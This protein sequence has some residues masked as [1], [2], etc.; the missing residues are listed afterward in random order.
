MSYLTKLRD[1]SKITSYT[2]FAK[3]PKTLDI[4]KSK[5]E[6]IFEP[7]LS[8]FLKIIKLIVVLLF[9]ITSQSLSYEGIETYYIRYDIKSSKNKTTNDNLVMIPA[10]NEFRTKSFSLK[11]ISGTI[12]AD[13][14]GSNKSIDDRVQHHALKTLLVHNGLKSV[15]SKDLDTVL[16]YEGVIITPLKIINKTYIEYENQYKYDAQIEFSPIAF[17]NEWEKL[18]MKNKIKNLFSDFFELFK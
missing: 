17:P 2:L 8:P 16:S 4:L 5:C 18:H 7:A 9:F 14:D 13:P 10:M 15:S 11:S 6:L 1:R 12:S 3:P